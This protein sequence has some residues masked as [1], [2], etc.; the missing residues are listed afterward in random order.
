MK[1]VLCLPAT[2]DATA[3]IES[4]S[5]NMKQFGHDFPILLLD[6]SD[7]KTANK[8]AKTASKLPGVRHIRQ[9]QIGTYLESI[10]APRSLLTAKPINTMDLCCLL[11]LSS[12]ADVLHRRDADTRAENFVSRK[13]SAPGLDVLG[14][15][16]A[17]IHRKPDEV[18][19]IS[20]TR[21]HPWADIQLT[22]SDKKILA[23]TGGVTGC[24]PTPF[25][26]F[27]DFPKGFF[28][29]NPG[30]KDSEK[31]RQR[32]QGE[33]V[34]YDESQFQLFSSPGL[35]GKNLCLH[36]DAFEQNCCPPAQGIG[37]DD[38]H[39]GTLLSQQGT[40]LLFAYAPVGCHATYSDDIAGVVVKEFRNRDF[41]TARNHILE[42]APESL[43]SPDI[44]LFM[45]TSQ[46]FEDVRKE[47]ETTLRSAAAILKQA[48]KKSSRNQSLIS[49]AGYLERNIESVLEA[50]DQ[51]V[52]DWFLLQEKW[53]E[54]SRA[55]GRFDIDELF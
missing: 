15:H 31:L 18:K 3:A 45:T 55:A 5:T 34:L 35:C 47:R 20:E 52:K 40:P 4:Y 37:A 29:L 43:K 10:T 24:N 12:K 11:S 49:A 19:L 27:K 16:L 36:K 44:G 46:G 32:I 22:A 28:A 30:F 25:E 7:E 54:L 50:T 38:E 13:K 14:I 23:V 39:L 51:C 6:T 21:Y 2:G 8:N 41:M 48:P 42:T 9:A 1:S 26:V 33:P 53:P 17:F